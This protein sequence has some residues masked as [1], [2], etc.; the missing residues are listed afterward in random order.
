MKWENTTEEKVLQ[1]ARDEIWRSWRHTCA[2][3]T[4]HPRAKELYNPNKLP[5]FHD[6][7]AGGGTLPLEAH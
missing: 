2:E 5:A 1:P 6:P 4:G 7:F 3:S